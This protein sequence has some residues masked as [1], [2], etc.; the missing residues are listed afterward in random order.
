MFS[1][2]DFGPA[3]VWTNGGS[4]TRLNFVYIALAAVNLLT[5]G[6]AVFVGYR[7]LELIAERVAEARNWSAKQEAVHV[8][9]DKAQAIFVPGNDIF[10]SRDP[11]GER[12]KLDNAIRQ[13][14]SSLAGVRE[15]LVKYRDPDEGQT[16]DEQLGG[17]VEAI[18]RKVRQGQLLGAAIIKK[19]EDNDATA[20]SVANTASGLMAQSDRISARVDALI[21]A[22]SEEMADDFVAD[23]VATGKTAEDYRKSLAVFGALMILLVIGTIA[24]GLNLSRVLRTSAR[25][26][27]QQ[28]LSIA[29]REKQLEATNVELENANASIASI[30]QRAQ[31]GIEAVSEGYALFDKDYRLVQWNAK[32]E[33]LFPMYSGR[34]AVGTSA[35]DLLLWTIDD[36]GPGDTAGEPGWID[37]R[38][39]F[40]ETPGVPF[41]QVVGGRTLQ[42]TE[43]RT[44]EGGLVIIH[45]DVTDIRAGEDK[46]KEKMAQ[47][48]K[49]LESVRVANQRARDAISALDV[50][51]SLFDSEDRLL[52]WNQVYEEMIPGFRGKLV[53]GKSSAE[54]AKIA[55]AAS[56]PSDDC[57]KPDWAKKRQRRRFA[58]GVPFESIVGGRTLEIVEH[59]TAEGGLVCV[60]RDVTDARAQAAELNDAKIAAER[61]SE[62]KTQFLA[63]M[64]HEIRTPLNGVIGMTEILLESELSQEQRMQVEIARGAADQLLQVIGNVLD[65]SKLESGAF[66]LE[67]SPFDL[68]PL[69]ESA[70]QTV[71]AKAMAKGIEICIDIDAVAEGWYLGDPTRL[72]QILLNFLNN[73]VKF[74]DHGSIVAAVH[75]RPSGPGL[76]SLTFSVSDTGIGMTPE[77]SAKIFQKFVQADNSITRRFGGTG[78]GLAISKQLIETM[79]GQVRVES[80]PGRGSVFSFELFLPVAAGAAAYDPAQLAGKRA[81]VVDDLELNRTILNNV[82]SRWG[83]LVDVATDAIAGIDALSAP[84][85]AYDV[86]L[87]DRNMPV[88]DG[89]EFGSAIRGMALAK[90]PKLVL[91]GSTANSA[92]AAIARVFDATLF[93]PIQSRVLCESLTALLSGGVAGNGLAAAGAAS[94]SDGVAGAKILL[95][96]DN[97]TNQYAATTILRQIGCEVD[98]A[99]NGRIAV[100]KCFSRAY[101]LI[102]MDMQ[103]PVLD[104]IAATKLIRS[105]PN[106]NRHTPIL[107]LTANAFVEDAE[108]CK[109]AGMNEHLT[110]PL[111]K[112]VLAA[113]LARHIDPGKSRQATKC[114][115]AVATN[116]WDALVEDFGLEGV[117]RLA[118]TFERQQGAELSTMSADDRADLRRKAHSLKGSAKLFG[119][120]ALAGLA[121]RLEAI[122]MEADANEIAALTAAIMSD[123]AVVCGEIKAKLA[124]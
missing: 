22:I 31:D 5:V 115:P 17:R 108:R 32:I 15:T 2:Q 42:L 18:V 119:A 101:D 94:I 73:S 34:L 25:E 48:N 43:Y 121:I 35:L 97:E 21:H 104:G 51:F 113:A 89:I 65:I 6:A 68:G 95:V 63:N 55:Y 41:E 23:L 33:E 39:S 105:Q 93:K 59:R 52:I 38:A 110:K 14:D 102:L 57:R 99:E 26:R 60:H 66:E 72:R 58:L 44:K 122:A 87:V 84:G 80:V 12:E 71:A 19:F 62:A 64:S 78:L 11:A 3:R 37:R 16:T 83:M 91:C 50:G 45:R 24:Y 61:A 28:L 86:V 74:T 29:A 116:T 117:K 8:F 112:S 1:G 85:P 114:A 90:Q 67:S 75:G 123:F 53:P 100:E 27:E 96:E 4:G 111:R 77:Q 70:V 107:A 120:E 88:M 76:A 20:T 36:A 40:H 79:G 10:L 98:L 49:A 109:A 54:L 7:T 81:L 92:A 69:V 118:D 13:F 56:S 124:A 9:A 47:L 46:L 82:L 106:Q 30:I 103:M